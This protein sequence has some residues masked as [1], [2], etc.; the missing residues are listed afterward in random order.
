MIENNNGTSYKH[1]QQG[2]KIID[3]KIDEKEKRQICLVQRS[4]YTIG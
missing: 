1:R 4:I 2:D 3:N